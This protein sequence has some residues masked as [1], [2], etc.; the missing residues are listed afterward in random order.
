MYQGGYIHFPVELSQAMDN[1]QQQQ[2]GRLVSMSD[3]F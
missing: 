1:F 3:Y 2:T